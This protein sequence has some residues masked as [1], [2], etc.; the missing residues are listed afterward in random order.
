MPTKDRT[1]YAYEVHQQSDMPIVTAPPQ[2]D[3]MDATDQRFAYRCLPLVVANQAGWLILNP[4]NFAVRWNGGPRLGD[5]R[6]WFRGSR[7]ETRIISHFGH[8]VLTF[9]L[10]YL[11]RT[12]RGVNLWVKGPSN[13]I[14]D[15]AQPL[16]GV[17][18]TD[19]SAATFTMNW[20]LTRPRH[21]VRFERGEPI[22]MIVP[23]PRGLAESFQPRRMPLSHNAQLLAKYHAWQLS[24][25]AF[26]DALIK[27]RPDAVR[28][29][30][31]RDYFLGL[32]SDGKRFDEHQTRL[33]LKE[34]ATG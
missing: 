18:E 9:S 14:K 11:F 33:E 3:W 10:P 17:V 15:G 6:I 13:W 25:G 31:Q 29:G 4:A 12:P 28:R 23:I 8:G 22:C 19:W 16:E 2:R 24:R 34:F 21:T 20:K 30:W 7:R 1:L 26:L 5:T 32:P 27:Q